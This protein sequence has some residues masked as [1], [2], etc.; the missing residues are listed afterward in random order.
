MSNR[1]PPALYAAAFILGLALLGYLTVGF[2]GAL[3]SSAFVGG[4][5][6][7]L[8]T[9]YRTPV[10][11]AAVIVPYLLTV[12]CFV[13]HVYEEYVSHVEH[14]L[15]RLSGFQVTQT[16]FLMVA[17]F[18]APVVWL[19]GAAVLLKRWPFG[20]FFASTFLFGMMFAELSHFLSP[21]MEDGAFHY[22]PGM[23]TAALPV[24]SGWLTF[25]VVLRE[26]RKER[27]A[28]EDAVK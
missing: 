18:S 17:A 3:F 11:P 19:S 21:F 10:D 4:F 15:S 1:L 6:L 23:Y 25:R 16:D 8:L 12:I 13:V 28:G 14:T 20:Y 22:S 2:A 24:I 5:V 27:L 7:W 9:T 26:M